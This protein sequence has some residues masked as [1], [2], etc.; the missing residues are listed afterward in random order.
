MVLVRFWGGGRVGGGR[1][2]GTVLKSLNIRESPCD[3][4]VV[5]A[6]PKGLWLKLTAEV[7]AA[8]RL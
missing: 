6:V 8:H 7:G 4:D 5:M 2:M 3:I 1:E